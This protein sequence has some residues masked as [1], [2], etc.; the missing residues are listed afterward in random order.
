M[1]FS[2]TMPGPIVTLARTFLTKPVHIRAEGAE[3]SFTHE[4]IKKVTFQAHKMDKGAVLAKALQAEGR[5]K[6]IIFT[7]TKRTAAEAP[8]ISPSAALPSAPSTATSTRRPASAPSRPSATARSTFSSPRTSPP[9]ASTSTTS[10][11]SST[12]RSRMTR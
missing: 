5:G 4:Q 6:T 11:T 7:R 10:H 12:T 3:E 8:T 9:A 1:L 2:A